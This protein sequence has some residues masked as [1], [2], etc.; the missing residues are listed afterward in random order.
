LRSLIIGALGH[1][2]RGLRALYYQHLQE[3]SLLVTL[4]SIPENRRV[5]EAAF[6][7]EFEAASN[8]VVA[9]EHAPRALGT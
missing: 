5:Q 1:I 2:N 3:R 7:S 8:A 4:P 6:W 9:E